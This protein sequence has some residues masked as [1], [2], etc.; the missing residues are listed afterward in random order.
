MYI[1]IFIYFIYL[2]AIFVSDIPPGP[3][4]MMG[5]PQPNVPPPPQ[6]VPAI[7]QQTTTTGSK[8]NSL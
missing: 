1:C 5:P 2:I 3:G 7:P 4:M 6:P 8:S